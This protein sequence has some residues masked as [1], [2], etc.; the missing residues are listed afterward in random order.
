MRAASSRVVTLWITVLCLLVTLFSLAGLASAQAAAGSKRKLSQQSLLSEHPVA[1]MA[2][3]RRATRNGPLSATTDTWQGGA[4]GVW[5]TPGNW[6]NGAITTGENILINLTTAATN[7]DASFSI[8]TL[9]LNVAGD[10]ATINNN[11][12]LTVA[13]NITNNG[14]IT[15]NSA[16]N[17]TE[18]VIGAAGVT[19]SGTG[20]VNLS[21]NGQNFIFGAAAADKLTNQQ[22][23]QGSGNIGDGQMALANS[24]TIDATQSTNLILQTSNGDTN[25]GTLEATTGVLVLQGDTITNT[26]GTIK[27]TGSAVQLNGVTVNGGTLTTT[28]S[29]LIHTVSGQSATL[30]NLTNSGNYQSDNNSSTTLVGTI[31]NSK[32]INLASGGNFTALALSGNVTLGGTGTVTMSNNSQ[33]FIYGAIASDILTVGSGQ[34]ISGSGTIG[35]NGSVASMAL[36][37]NGIINATQST[38]LIIRTSN[39]DTNT[40]TMEATT[41]TLIFTG[42]TVTQTGSGNISSTGSDVQ[43]QGSRSMAARSRPRE[44]A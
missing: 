5:S 19:L 3:A 26:G 20:T 15:L 18:L 9:T 13:G 38:P 8:G 30:E 28:G 36:V 34:T 22:T 39:G 10:S 25:T 7:V 37:N 23:I 14:T 41:G 24:G 1:S 6:N 33:N 27:S 16:G 31:T 32:N 12:G 40:G 17:V 42:D 21:N 29:G 2:G 35:F 44:R 43:L 11:V 4:S